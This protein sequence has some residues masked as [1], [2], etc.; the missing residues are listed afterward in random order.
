MRLNVYVGVPNWNTHHDENFFPARRKN[1]F[2]ASGP[3]ATRSADLWQEELFI[4]WGATS[5][6]RYNRRGEVASITSDNEDYVIYKRCPEEGMPIAMSL[7]LYREVKLLTPDISEER[8]QYVSPL[9]VCVLKWPVC[10]RA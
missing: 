2:K 10:G 8:S 9:L 4:H 3:P 1:S 7:V 6:V 5:R